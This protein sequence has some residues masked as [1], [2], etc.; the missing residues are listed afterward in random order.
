MS[1]ATELSLTISTTKSGAFQFHVAVR[2]AA[3]AW[4]QA[5]AAGVDRLGGQVN[6]VRLRGEVRIRAGNPRAIAEQ[7]P[8]AGRPNYIRQFPDYLGLDGT[9]KEK[10]FRRHVN[11]DPP[12]DVVDSAG[13]GKSSDNAHVR[14]SANERK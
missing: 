12:A 4:H 3:G 5:N 9:M 10:I 11:L 8:A 13:S 14:N 7:I 1:L 6:D 2:F